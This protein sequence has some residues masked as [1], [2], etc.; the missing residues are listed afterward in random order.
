[1]KRLTDEQIETQ[2]RI[3]AHIKTQGSAERA[4]GT[5]FAIAEALLSEVRA[6]RAPSPLRVAV[7]ALAKEWDGCGRRTCHGTCSYCQTMRPLAARLRALLS[8]PA[9]TTEPWYEA[10]GSVTML[11]AEEVT[12]RR[13]LAAKV[14]AAAR[15]AADAATQKVAYDLWVIPDAEFQALATALEAFATNDGDLYPAA[16]SP[17]I[18]DQ[19]TI[20]DKE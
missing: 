2:G 11:P 1:M 9:P 5:L 12:M 19:T 14:L 7:E 15:K 6:S 18:G 4:A 20:N 8:A 16:P 3:L 17:G 13:K 10:D